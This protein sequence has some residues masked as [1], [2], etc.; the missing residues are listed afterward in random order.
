MNDDIAPGASQGLESALRHLEAALAI[1]DRIGAPPG[2]GAH[3][4]LAVERVK[5]QLSEPQMVFK[6]LFG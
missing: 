5:E 3:V 4:D 6:R 2:L 1:L